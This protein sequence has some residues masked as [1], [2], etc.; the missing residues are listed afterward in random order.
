MRERNKALI[1]YG[2]VAFALTVLW[3]YFS[4]FM[5]KLNRSLGLIVLGVLFLGGG[6]ALEKLRRRMVSQVKEA[7]A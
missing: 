4:N 1:N 5:D 7:T 6:W 3:F 2:V